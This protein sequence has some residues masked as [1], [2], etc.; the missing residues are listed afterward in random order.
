M[1]RLECGPGGQSARLRPQ[2]ENR[3]AAQKVIEAPYTFAPRLKN[4]N[5]V[6]KVLYFELQMFNN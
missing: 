2:P 4:T 5:R 6:K 3:V 1:Q